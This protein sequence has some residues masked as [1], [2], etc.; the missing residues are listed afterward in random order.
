MALLTA[1]AALLVFED[2]RGQAQGDGQP[3]AVGI[4]TVDVVAAG[5]EIESGERIED[6]H[7][8]RKDIAED[9]ADIRELTGATGQDHARDFGIELAFDVI[10]RQADLVGEIF[11]GG[12]GRVDDRFQGFPGGELHGIDFIGLIV[13]RARDGVADLIASE[14]DLAGEKQAIGEHDGDVGLGRTDIDDRRGLAFALGR[15]RRPQ[16]F[17]GIGEREDVDV[18]DLG[19]QPGSAQARQM[20]L[21]EAFAHR[22]QHHL[23]KI[24]VRAGLGRHRLTID[25]HLFGTE[26]DVLVGFVGDV[27]FELGILEL[28]RVHLTHDHRASGDGSHHAF[29]FQSQL[30]DDTFDDLAEVLVV[31]A[32]LGVALQCDAIAIRLEGHR[33]D[34]I[35]ANVESD[36]SL[37]AS[38]HAQPPGNQPTPCY[39]PGSRGNPVTGRGW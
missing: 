28:G 35:R 30:A 14:I 15:H 1:Q 3:G 7:R 26:G 33:L 2:V 19:H 20:L 37:G 12:H 38:E 11:E 22:H 6:E 13:Q 17:I 29:G 16:Q 18:D 21:Y 10:E 25:D 32:G 24:F 31:D 27:L 8:A 34:G 36:H 23:L 4:E 9:V 5:H 39:S